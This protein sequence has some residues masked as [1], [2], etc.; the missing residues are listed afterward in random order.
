VADWLHRV[1][2]GI[3]PAT[4]GYRTI[5]F[6]PQPGGGFTRASAEHET[7]YGRASIEWRVTDGTLNVDVVVP[8]GADA[9]VQ[10]PGAEPFSIESGSHS[11][12]QPA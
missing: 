8:T 1:V 10:L 7:P 12:S 4:P 2:A 5:Q 6:A 11:F 9:I 3:A